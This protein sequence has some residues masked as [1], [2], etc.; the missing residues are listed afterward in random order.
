MHLRTGLFLTLFLFTL[1]APRIKDLRVQDLS[2]IREVKYRHFLERRVKHNTIVKTIQEL[3]KHRSKRSTFFTTGVKICPQEKMKDVLSSHRVYYKLRVCQEAIWEAFRIFL[4][5]VPNSEEYKHWTYACQHGSLCLDEVA[6]NFSRTQEHID[7]VARRVSEQK[8]IHEESKLSTPEGTATVKCEKTPSDLFTIPTDAEDHP[9]SLVPQEVMLE[10]QVVEFSVTIAEPGYSDL[11]LSDPTAPQFYDVTR[12][13]HNMMVHVFEK[14]PGFKD[15]RILGFRLVELRSDDVSVRYAV[16]FQTNGEG[17]DEETVVTLEPGTGTVVYTN[18]QRLKDM[19][20]KALSKET[21]LPVDIHTLSFEPDPIGSL[22]GELEATT[23]GTVLEEGIWH[24]KDFIPSVSVG[25]LEASTD[26]PGDLMVVPSSDSVTDSLIEASTASHKTETAP[27]EVTLSLFSEEV[28]KKVVDVTEKTIEEK[29]PEEQSLE[30][31]TKVDETAVDSRK[32]TTDLKESAEDSTEKILDIVEPPVVV[33]EKTVNKAESVDKTV[34]EGDLVV[35]GTKEMLDVKET[36]VDAKAEKLDI[37]ETEDNVAESFPTVEPKG[38][39]G[40]ATTEVALEDRPEGDNYIYT[41]TEPLDVETFTN[42]IQSPTMPSSEDDNIQAEAEEV[43]SA[44]ILPVD[45]GASEGRETPQE[46]E[47]REK[48]MDI[49]N[50]DMQEDV[51]VEQVEEDGTENANNLDESGSGFEGPIESTAPPALRHMNTPLMATKEKAKEM[52]VFFSLRVTNMMFSEDLFD[53]SS[54]EYRSLENTFLELNQ[55][56]E[57][58]DS[59]NPGAS[60]SRTGRQRTLA[61]IPVFPYWNHFFHASESVTY[62]FT[63]LTGNNF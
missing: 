22:H 8:N 45:P 60:H 14:L 42:A 28:K 56:S 46:D 7:M 48:D 3:D 39:E 16:V 15:L 43:P 21:S 47:S 19:V 31:K 11:I 12:N 51:D 24:D 10:E 54:P 63:N 5:R 35:D 36:A 25:V 55:F 13:L 33:T 61:S 53:K 27:E 62:F 58:G 40:P 50:D 37:V 34:K 26:T 17:H 18:G 4:D 29:Q 1:A 49:S 20:S 6:M 57:A 30:K 44:S 52:V 41:N 59:P 23:F 9:A 2:G 38:D 32:E